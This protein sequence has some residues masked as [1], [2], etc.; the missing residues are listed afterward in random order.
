MTTSERIKSKDCERASSRALAALSHTVA[1]WPA[2]RNARASE[3]RVL[4]SSST[5]SR[6]AFWATDD[7]LILP[8][9][10]VQIAR[11]FDHKRCSTPRLAAHADPAAMVAHD[12]L[13]DGQSKS[14]AVCLAG[15]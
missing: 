9:Q 6:C 13:H 7:S 12:R 2:K 4:A 15:V 10:F 5:I 1:S 8:G 11:Q 3:A 14:G